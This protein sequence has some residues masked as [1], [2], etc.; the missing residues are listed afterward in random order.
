M[1][2]PPKVKNFAWKAASDALAT[3][4]NKKRRKIKVTGVCKICCQ[5]TEDTAHA[6]VRCPHA[7]QLWEL[8]QEFWHVPSASDF[9]IASPRWFRTV[10]M[11]IPSQMVEN[12]LLVA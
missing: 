12:T 8:M 5:E 7:H 3:E 1:W 9:Y 10:L 4:D 6:L 2:E 11:D